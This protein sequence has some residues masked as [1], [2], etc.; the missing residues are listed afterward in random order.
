MKSNKEEEF[1]NPS[2]VFPIYGDGVSSFFDENKL[3]PICS[4]FRSFIDR[5]NS[6]Q[7]ATEKGLR[8]TSICDIPSWSD[9]HIELKIYANGAALFNTHCGYDFS[10]PSVESFN[11]R[12]YGLFKEA[13]FI[14]FHSYMWQLEDQ[15]SNKKST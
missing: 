10:N 9:G 7:W 12:L 1:A 14:G 5:L 13:L 8:F 3:P 2:L 15:L 11:E 4:V 6:C